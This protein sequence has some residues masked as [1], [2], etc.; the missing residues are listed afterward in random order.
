MKKNTLNIPNLLSL[1]RVLLVPAF[2]LT[3]LLMTDAEFLGVLI[4]A[5]I[6][7]VTALT[8][9]LDGQLARRLGMVTDFG[10]FIDPLADKFMVIASLITMD[11][12]MFLM[13]ES[14]EALVF[15]PVILIILLR[16]LM[17]TSL[18]L[19]VAGKSGEVVAASIFGKIKTVSQMVG[20]LIILL[21]YYVFPFSADSHVIAYIVMVIMTVATVLSGIDY[22]RKYLPC[23]NTNE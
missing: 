2:V 6:Y 15:L 23:I 1:L 21:E 5:L 12:W 4:P 22:L 3:L 13:G 20:T 18:R 14:T 17:V 11:V 10:K 8:D 19:V 7:A 9:F 16:E